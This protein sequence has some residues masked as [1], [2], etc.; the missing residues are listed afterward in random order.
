M[1]AFLYLRTLW[2]S[3][4]KNLEGDNHTLQIALKQASF[5][6]LHVMAVPL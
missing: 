3:S 6:K 4:G 1:R 2:T 5:K